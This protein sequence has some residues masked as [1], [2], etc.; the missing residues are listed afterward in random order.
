MRWQ[1]CKGEPLEPSESSLPWS[2]WAEVCR[3]VS[4]SHGI[5]PAHRCF[6]LAVFE[7]VRVTQASNRS[8]AGRFTAKF[9]F[10][11]KITDSLTRERGEDMP[12]RNAATPCYGCSA[13]V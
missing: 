11:V 7:F 1:P 12:A 2:G 13:A 4:V 3:T 9:R 6:A 10:P 5:C 8:R